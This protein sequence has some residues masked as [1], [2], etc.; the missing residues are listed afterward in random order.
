ML[1]TLTATIAVPSIVISAP[2][3]R[4]AILRPLFMVI[5][6]VSSE[7]FPDSIPQLPKDFI[8]F[9]KNIQNNIFE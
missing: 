5:H 6:P 9:L 2:R 8:L 3:E 1:A 7:I 4:V